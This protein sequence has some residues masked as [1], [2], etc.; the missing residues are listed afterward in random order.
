MTPRRRDRPPRPRSVRR[1]RLFAPP[2]VSN[3]AVGAANPRPPRDVCDAMGAAGGTSAEAWAPRFV[4]SRR[5]RR[6]GVRVRRRRRAR[7][8]SGT[9]R[10][11]D[12]R[13]G[14]RGGRGRVP[15][16]HARR[17]GV[18]TRRDG[19]SR[20]RARR[21]GARVLRAT[22][23]PA[24]VV[25]AILL[26][27]SSRTRTPSPSDDESTDFLRGRRAASTSERVRACRGRTKIACVDGRRRGRATRTPPRRVFSPRGR[28]RG[29]IRARA[30]G[31]R[32]RTRHGTR[33]WTRASSNRRRV[34]PRF[35]CP[36][37]CSGSSRRS[38]RNARGSR[39]ARNGARRVSR[40]WARVSPATSRKE[41]R[42]MRATGTSSAEERTRDEPGDGARGR[43]P[44]TRP[45]L[46]V[47]RAGRDFDDSTRRT[48][49]VEIRRRRRRRRESLA[50]YRPVPTFSTE[51]PAATVGGD[52]RRE[53]ID[54]DSVEEEKREAREER[55]RRRTRRRR[56][57]RD[58]T[59][60]SSSAASSL[61]A[62]IAN[63]VLTHIIDV[64]RLIERMG[65]MRAFEQDVDADEVTLRAGAT[66][67][68]RRDICTPRLITKVHP[69]RQGVA[70]GGGVRRGIPR[71][72]SSAARARHGAVLHRIAR[73]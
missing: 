53:H 41:R 70:L 29:R 10:R 3:S 49:S 11:V 58:S 25:D 23:Y 24:A 42:R 52:V 73:D 17:G 43:S 9:S 39:R 14:R 35:P 54:V 7:R 6:R 22:A 46:R 69:R 55:A 56:T 67:R 30:T 33:R 60:P 68:L 50:V 65:E 40:G 4:R 36:R 18:R 66:R 21:D 12:R 26:D 20:A 19:R 47:S 57:N 15:D 45:R 5:R 44:K 1:C 16:A 28:T 64:D 2:S 34:R 8:R 51:T 62:R 31:E 38:R 72:R 48:A 13:E 63:T 61:S 37:T 27:D 71:A 32:R 59:P